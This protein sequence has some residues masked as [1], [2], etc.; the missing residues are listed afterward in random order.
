M[1]FRVAGRNARDVLAG[2]AEAV[3]RG[4]AA[5]SGPFR[6]R[7]LDCQR[8]LGRDYPRLPQAYAFESLAQV[9]VF[10]VGPLLAAG[11]IATLG[12]GATLAAT[13]GLLL[14]SALSFSLL[15]LG[16]RAVRAAAST[17]RQSPIRI[18][19]LQTLVLATVVADAAL[20]I[21]DVTVVAFAKHHGHPS[22]AGL[23]LAVF[24][25][26]SVVDGRALRRA[27][28]GDAYATAP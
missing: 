3:N 12:P 18:P 11:G 15:A 26:A 2:A 24:C 27:T 17:T 6:C 23:L 13:G 5:V 22:A 9:S 1:G 14:A 20:G 28:M 16:D 4:A 7:A 21:A 25:S 19:G 10:V 8:L